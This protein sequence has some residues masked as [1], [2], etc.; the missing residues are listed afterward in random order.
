MLFRGVRPLCVNVFI[1]SQPRAALVAAPA[2]AFSSDLPWMRWTCA[3]AAEEGRA[4]RH[5]LAEL[6]EKALRNKEMFSQVLA[7]MNRQIEKLVDI[8]AGTVWG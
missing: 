2:A 3:E 8:A 7:S 4:R 1:A 5:K 6:E